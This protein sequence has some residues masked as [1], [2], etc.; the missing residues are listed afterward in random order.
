MNTVGN[1]SMVN[2]GSAGSLRASSPDK[3]DAGEARRASSLQGA[4]VLGTRAI[5]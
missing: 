4:W 1:G 3:V 2:C 5:S